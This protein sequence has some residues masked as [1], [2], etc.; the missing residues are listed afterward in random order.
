MNENLASLLRNAVPDPGR[1]FLERDDG[2]VLRYR[3]ADEASARIAHRLAALGVKP[4]DRVAIQVE[5]SP[6]AIFLYLACLRAGA[7]CLPLN[8]AYTLAELDYY[9]GDATPELFV[10]A[11]D[12]RDSLAP[13][14]A[15]HGARL[16]TLD[17]SGGGSLREGIA[18]L[19]ARFDDVERAA[20]DLAAILYTSGTTGRAKGAMITHA[21]LSSNAF[22]L[23]KMW[24]FTGED[25]LIHAL[26]LFHVHG[27]F[28]AVNTVMAAGASLILLPKLD[29]ARILALFART[30][31]LM[32]VPTFYTRLLQQPGLDA[33][34]TAGMRLFVSGSA[35]LSAETHAEWKARTGHA[36][37]E[38]YG[39]TETGMN[40]SNSYEGA[41]KPGSVGPPLPG[42]EV[43]IVDAESGKPLAQGEIGAIEVRGPNVFK[44]YWKMPE[45][46]AA[47]FRPDGFFITGDV[48]RIDADG[49]VWIVG[50]AKDLIITG[51][52]NVYPAEVEG[53]IDAV[54]GVAECAVIGLPDRDFGEAVTAVVARRSGAS[55]DAK[56]VSAALES[57]LARY[58]LPKRI[59]FVPALPRNAMGKI[60][61]NVLREALSPGG[62]PLAISLEE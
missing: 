13:V 50:R 10:C 60:Q 55:V 53:E 45:K 46:T 34:A 61:K 16:A 18:A 33:R 6:D 41:R 5:K 14:A 48:G 25:R 24:R 23:A 30:T 27:L 54:A 19:P 57:R 28:V 56:A 38:R 21:N 39:M 26:P 59:Y 35:P 42:V 15:K 58:K 43:R 22:T 29:P 11:P 20:G 3:D 49:Y 31:T 2:V 37:L 9:I 52:Y 40:T 47:E 51:G 4:G 62:N 44:G 17:E 8:T 32:G 1:A 12:R 36:I 7:A